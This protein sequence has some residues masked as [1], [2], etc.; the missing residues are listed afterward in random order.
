MSSRF[1][2]EAAFPVVTFLVVFFLIIGFFVFIIKTVPPDE[3]AYRMCIYVWEEPILNNFDEVE[4]ECAEEHLY[5]HD[6]LR[7]TR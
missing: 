7:T 2:A 6:E 5:G 1:D 3:G 4:E